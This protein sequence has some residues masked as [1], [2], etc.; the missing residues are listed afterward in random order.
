VRAEVVPL[1]R[2]AN[3]GVV[4]DVDRRTLR[5]TRVGGD[6][7]VALCG[8][9]AADQVVGAIFRIDNKPVFVKARKGVVLATGGF[10]MPTLRLAPGSPGYAPLL[11][12][13]STAANAT[14]TAMNARPIM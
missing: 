12:S 11:F 10:V 14:Q 3:S 9:R 4:T 8:R 1:H 7:D 6:D 2:V 13:S 5:T